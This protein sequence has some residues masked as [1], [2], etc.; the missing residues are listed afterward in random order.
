MVSRDVRRHRLILISYI[1]PR[2]LSRHGQRE[3]KG[4]RGS[5][6]ESDDVVYGGVVQL[7]RT[8]ACH[9]GGRGFESRRSRH[10][11]TC[12]PVSSPVLREPLQR[13]LCAEGLAVRCQQQSRGLPLRACQPSL[14][15]S[16][17][18]HRAA[19]GSAQVIPQKACA[20]RPARAMIDKYPQSADSTASA[21]SAALAVKADS[22]CFCYASSGIPTAATINTT[23][24][25]TLG[26]TSPCPSSAAQ[27]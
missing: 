1:S 12:E 27:R 6:K 21:L 15:T 4:T 18:R 22:R 2:P 24:P 23:I 20:T 19:R 26:L 16:G 13:V 25:R 8:P 9:A 7:I 17:I 11:L 14:I 10:I 3:R 5:R